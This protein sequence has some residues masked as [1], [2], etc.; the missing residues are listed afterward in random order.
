MLDLIIKNGEVVSVDATLKMDVG[1]KDGKVILLGKAED[2]PKT[3]RV[4]DATGKYVIPGGIDTH[5]HFQLPFMG[6]ATK[7][8]F[9]EGTRAAAYGGTTT[10]IDF[11][12]Q[13]KGKLPME[14]IQARMVQAKDSVVDYAFHSVITD[15]YPE[16]IANIKDLIEFGVPSF[17]CFMIYRKD[18]LMAD[19]AVVLAAMEQTKKYNGIFGAHAESAAML[20]YNV[21]KAVKEGHHEAIWH[22]LTKPPLVESEAINRALYLAAAADAAYYNFHTACKEGVEMIAEARAKGRPVY[23]ETCTHYLSITKDVLEGPD[24]INYICS[25]ALRDQE[26]IDALW[27]GIQDGT[28]VTIGSDEAAFDT[29]QKMIA[30]GSFEKVPNGMPG[31]EFR[32]PIVFSEGVSKGKISVNQ[33]VAVTSTNAAKIHGIFPQKGIIS[34]GSDADIVLIDPNMEKTITPDDFKIDIDWNPYNGM[35][36]KGWPIMTISKGKVIVEDNKF[37]GNAKDGSFL[38]RKLSPNANTNPV[39]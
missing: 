31:V 17:K 14:A 29:K 19:D 5:T 9:F 3:V 12:I 13:E 2:M 39:V 27:K 15:A 26:H 30:G 4:I 28:V 33:Y 11:A 35:K 18:G 24:G 38:K 25:P 21:E 1:I 36:A 10:C 6:T 32:M 16:A 8:S 37:L 7:D 22:A 20:E 34:I 23:A